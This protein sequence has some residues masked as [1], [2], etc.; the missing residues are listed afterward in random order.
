MA[1][2]DIK[3]GILRYLRQSGQHEHKMNL[4]GRPNQPGRVEWLLG[5]TFEPAQRVL[6]DRSFE[7]LKAAGLIQPTYRDLV[8][9]LEW[10]EISDAGR[11]A[12]DRNR[13]NDLDGA[14]A[15]ID[16]R[17][18]GVRRGVWAALGS[19]QPDAVRQAAHSARELVDQT[20]HELAPIDEV[21]AQRWFQP[22]KT[23][24]SGVTRRMRLATCDGEV[25]RRSI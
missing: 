16:P 18:V 1:P 21:K 20:L 14:L 3:F 15:A 9:P 12:L 25:P 17:L 6:A 23:S 4:L 24:Q 7:E 5:V 19:G 11:E 10:V 8:N 2:H 13:L 22:D